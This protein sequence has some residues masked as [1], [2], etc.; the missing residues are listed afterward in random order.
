MFLR[1]YEKKEKEEEA[2][3]ARGGEQVFSWNCKAKK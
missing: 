3:E 2:G 1:N